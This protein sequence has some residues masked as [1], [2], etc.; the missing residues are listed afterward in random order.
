MA[1]PIP[2]NFRDLFEK[3]VYVA[4]VTVMPSG[5]P[6]ATVVWVDYD[7]ANL[8]VNTA[9][10]RQKDRNMKP[11][12]RVTVLAIDPQNPFRWIEVRG[13][14]I[15]ETEQGALEHI[16]KLSLKYRGEPD[17]YARSP[18]RRGKETRVI[19]RIEPR[20]VNPYGH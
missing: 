2:D 11:G 8:L 12:A 7:G 19:Y 10:G 6:Q 3:P 5:Q 9:R 4:L 18:E 17:Y 13:R 1:V 20:K 16:N 14:V 15:E